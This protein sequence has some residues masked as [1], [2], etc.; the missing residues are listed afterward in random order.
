MLACGCG[1]AAKKIEWRPADVE[2]AS[3]F[4]SLF[5]TAAE[6]DELAA[7]PVPT[8]APADLADVETWTLGGPTADRFSIE[9]RASK[10]SPWDDIVD[11]ALAKSD[12]KGRATESA[13]CIARELA[14]F[15][16]KN[17]RRDPV[18]DLTSFIAARCG[19]DAGEVDAGF[20]SGE[21]APSVPDAAIAKQVAS[22]LEPKLAE[23]ASQGR[24]IGLAVHREKKR[25]TMAMVSISRNSDVQDFSF[26]PE[27]DGAVR[28]QGRLRADAAKAVAWAAR[29]SL[30]FEQCESEGLKLPAF[31]FT[32]HVS[33]DDPSAWIVVSAQATEQSL[34]YPVFSTIVFPA[35]KPVDAYRRPSLDAAGVD[36]GDLVGTIN[37]AR[38]KA[39]VPPLVES[40]P[41]SAVARRVAG[42][43]LSGH[44]NGLLGP[45][46]GTSEQER[47]GRGLIAGWGVGQPLR[48]GRF[49]AADFPTGTSASRMIASLLERPDGRSVLLDPEATIGAAGPLLTGKGELL[50]AL[51]ST[52]APPPHLYG[53]TARVAIVSNELGKVRGRAGKPAC[54]RI[55]SLDGDAAE[56]ADAIESK[57]IK[58]ARALQSLLQAVSD[59][60]HRD[61]NGWAIQAESLDD[62]EVPPEL[63][64]AE[65]AQISVGVAWAQAPGDPW[66][67]WVVLLVLIR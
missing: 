22:V 30:G 49:L 62:L 56:A 38:A 55:T 1:H 64:R 28:F 41:E 13:A 25:V 65:L 48:Y 43:Y 37:A 32:C 21:V 57:H 10:G 9:P 45:T 39:G 53:Q 2:Q 54:V 61:V 34:L 7:A 3:D 8:A 16:G 29:G 59:K 20:Q 50:G 36:P 44:E 6:L 58:P 26:V 33:K 52:Y 31:A 40:K 51:L 15:V 27:D 4:A 24:E 12:G 47:I 11:A 5:P 19:A 17:G 35:G 63:G 23:W 14:R 46:Q 18:Q 67:R 66:G 42:H 60:T